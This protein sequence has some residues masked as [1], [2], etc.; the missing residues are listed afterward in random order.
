MKKLWLH[1]PKASILILIAASLDLPAQGLS[2]GRDTISVGAARGIYGSFRSNQ[3]NQGLKATQV[4]K[5]N[6]TQLQALMERCRNA[7]Y[8]EIQFVIATLRVQDIAHYLGHHPG[9]DDGSQKELI[10]RQIL[11]VRVPRAAFGLAQQRKPAKLNDNRLMI[12]LSAIGLTWLDKPYNL[13]VETDYLYFEIGN[14][15]PPPG[16]CD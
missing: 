15:C 6:I 8:G 4:V 14:I 12:S 3:A 13:S 11:L 16:T 2:L 7:G 5:F 9:L 1:L 10:G